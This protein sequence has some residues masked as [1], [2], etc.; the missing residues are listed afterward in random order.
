[1]DRTTQ[2][3]RTTKLNVICMYEYFYKFS[4][5]LGNELKIIRMSF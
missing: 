5:K 4:F 3:L 1:M 2:N